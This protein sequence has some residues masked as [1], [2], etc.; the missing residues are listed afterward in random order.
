MSFLFG[1]R[2]IFRGELLNFRGVK[3]EVETPPQPPPTSQHLRRIPAL[4][5]CSP[6][7]PRCANILALRS[8]TLVGKAGWQFGEVSAFPEP[9]KTWVQLQPTKLA[10]KSESSRRSE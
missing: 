5:V 7:F 8:M 3:P 2:P 1:A 9:Q 4:A 10:E 6:T